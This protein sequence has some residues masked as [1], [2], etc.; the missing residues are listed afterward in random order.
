LKE[1]E[2][3]ALV[4]RSRGGDEGAWRA[5][6]LALAPLVE[7]VAGR[8]RV[9]GRL[10][11]CPD[12][13]RDIV[14]EVMGSLR[15]DGFR[16]L[17]VMGE[18]LACRDGS[19]RRWLCTI[20]RNA[21][22]CHVRAHPEYL[23]TAPSGAGRWARHVPIPAERPDERP[24]LIVQIEVRRILTRCPEILEPAQLDALCL[25]LRGDELAEIAVA[26]E[27]GEDAGAAKLLVR[28]AVK[29]IRRFVAED[30]CLASLAPAAPAVPRVPEQ[31]GARGNRRGSR[32]RSAR[33]AGSE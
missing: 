33:R 1:E 30:R 3:E 10:S 27:L 24:S 23:G 28:A 29:R 31:A 21:A 18:R 15:E 2:L 11:R 5:L 7:Q 13:R 16:L 8:W 22:I 26:L 20:A 6:W 25:W 9:T 4:E 17:A 14:V 19:F 12:G 32:R